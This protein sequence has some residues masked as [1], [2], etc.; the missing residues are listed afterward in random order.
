MAEPFV[1]IGRLR[2]AVPS[3]FQYPPKEDTDRLVVVDNENRPVIHVDVLKDIVAA[4]RAMEAP[5]MPKCLDG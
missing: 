5:A 4:L 2:D 3:L 1:T